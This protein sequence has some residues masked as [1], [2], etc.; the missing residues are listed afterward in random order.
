MA[1]E[2]NGQVDPTLHTTGKFIYP[3]FFGSIRQSHQFQVC[4]RLLA[5]FQAAE[6]RHP[7]EKHQVIKSGHIRD[8]RPVPAGKFRSGCGQHQSHA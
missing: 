6:T 7:S 8:I 1:H 4:H 5:G 2:G 3:A